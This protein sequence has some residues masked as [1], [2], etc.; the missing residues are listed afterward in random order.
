M[1]ERLA[2]L[3]ARSNMRG[4][5]LLDGTGVVD[6]VALELA[7]LSRIAVKTGD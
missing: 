2:S 4:S 6:R 7:K 1:R 3:R 5:A